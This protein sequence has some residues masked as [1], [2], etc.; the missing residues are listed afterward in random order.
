M[1]NI[2]ISLILFLSQYSL[3]QIHQ[4]PFKIKIQIIGNQED[5]TGRRLVFK[6]KEIFRSSQ[7]FDLTDDDSAVMLIVFQTMPRY[8]KQP[9]SSTIYSIVWASRLIQSWPIYIDS[10]LG[11]CGAQKIDEV[12]EDL[13][14]DTDNVVSDIIKYLKKQ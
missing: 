9:D 4:E 10:T 6:M 3:N 8:P 13:V 11:Y 2:V 1:L 14:A 12:A 7:R 5:I